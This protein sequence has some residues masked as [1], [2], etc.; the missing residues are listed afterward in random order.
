[1]TDRIVK[2]HFDRLSKNYHKQIARHVRIHLIEKWWQLVSACFKENPYVLDVGCGD[3]TNVR[4]LRA[5]G[6]NAIGI[7]ASTELVREG[8][9]RNADLENNIFEGDACFLDFE[10]ATFD[11]VLMIGL[12][13]HIYPKIDQKKAIAEGLRVVKKDGF[14]IIRESNVTNPLFKMYWNY[15]FPITSKIDKFGGENWI[16]PSFFIKEN[17]NVVQLCYFTFIPDVTPNFLLP[18]ASRVESIFE[19]SFLK[20]LSAHYLIALKK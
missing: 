12:L 19:N 1:L 2:E 5:K 4:F 20:S 14:L 11:I 17:Y 10:D 7:D 18:L 8:K 13:H 16:K 3:G 9:N 15:V 6:I